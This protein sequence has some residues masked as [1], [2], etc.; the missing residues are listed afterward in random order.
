MQGTR[1]FIWRQVSGHACCNLSNE[2]SFEITLSVM[3]NEDLSQ[4]EALLGRLM[5]PENNAR[6]QAEV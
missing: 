3:A 2:T 6:Q 4:F 5:S 1:I